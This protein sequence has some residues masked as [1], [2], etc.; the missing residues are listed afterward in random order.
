MVVLRTPG[1]GSR[2]EA[3]TPAEQAVAALVSQGLSN[4]QIAQRRGRSPRTIA[5]QV[6]S[7]YIKLGIGSRQQLVRLLS[8]NIDT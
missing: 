3:L 2:L 4:A 5:N 6:R 7:I 8:E 1:Q